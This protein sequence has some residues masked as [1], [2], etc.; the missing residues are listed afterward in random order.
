MSP[1]ATNTM[2]PRQ[3]ARWAREM[4]LSTAV[5]SLPEQLRDR[6]APGTRYTIAGLWRQFAPDYTYATVRLWVIE[7]HGAGRLDRALRT[8]DRD[9]SIHWYIRR[10]S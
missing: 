9:T 8:L 4:A 6:M 5:P 7:L 10:A 2:T 3:E 1:V